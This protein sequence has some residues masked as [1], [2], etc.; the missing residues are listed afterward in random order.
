MKTY[1]LI[2]LAC[3]CSCWP[4]F[5][6]K[7]PFYDLKNVEYYF[8][9]FIIKYYRHYGNSEE[10]KLRHQIFVRNLK[11]INELNSNPKNKDVYDLNAFS[12]WTEEEILAT[13]DGSKVTS[14][15]KIYILRQY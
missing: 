9:D 15:E 10:R 12:D 2:L 7:K 5:I 14:E 11:K 8:N 13:L 1:G 6:T 3:V 4:K